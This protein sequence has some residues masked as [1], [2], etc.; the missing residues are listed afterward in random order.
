ML[1]AVGFRFSR[2]VFFLDAA[3]PELC[4]DAG[5]DKE[6]DGGRIN[7]SRRTINCSSCGS[8]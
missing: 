7:H 1:F 2:Q 6:H 4:V 3:R 5:A 8:S